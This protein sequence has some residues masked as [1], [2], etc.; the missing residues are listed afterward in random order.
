MKDILI[1]LSPSRGDSLSAG[2]QYAITLAGKHRTHLSALIADIETELHDLPPE[3]DIRQVERAKIK[4]TL[5]AD[6]VARMAE[7]VQSAA[8]D[9]GVS[10]DILQTE[11]QSVSLR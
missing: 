6:R 5:S 9:A 3:P 8:A 4:P 2:A 10:C 7:F 11:S 1:F